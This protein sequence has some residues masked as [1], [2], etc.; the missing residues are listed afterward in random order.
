MLLSIDWDYSSGCG[1][2]VFDAPIWGSTDSAFARAEAWQ[3]RLE[4]RNGDL[5]RFAAD[6][7]LFGDWA[8]AKKH[9]GVPTYA[10][11]SHADAYA[12]AKSLGM[13]RIINLDSHHDLYSG[14]GDVARLRPGN[15]AGLALQ[16]G[17]IAHYTCV[18]PAW[19][20]HLPVS[21]GFDLERTW[22]EINGRFSPSQ[23]TLTRQPLQ[24]LDCADLQAIIL[25]QS[26]AWSSPQHDPMFF[27][28]CQ[29][30]GAVNW[31]TAPLWRIWAS[32]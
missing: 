15:W 1:E 11:L 9:R 3:Q 16:H 13:T 21:E 24:S 5:E 20:Q 6:F 17:I 29:S 12:L 8:W 28:L 30:L 19:H 14:G 27:E 25:V 23:V 31:A 22:S 4:Q 26:P 10:T 7:P 18:Y 32:R 2:Q